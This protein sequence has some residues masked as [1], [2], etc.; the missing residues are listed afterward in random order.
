[1]PNEFLTDAKITREAADILHN[2][3]TFLGTINRQFDNSFGNAGAKIGSQLKIRMPN[4]YTVRT[5]RTANPQSTNETSEALV[6][7]TQKGVDFEFYSDELTLSMDDFKKRYL[8][9]QMSV[10]AANIEADAF[11]MFKDVPNIA[12]AT[13]TA[14]TT[15][16]P[17]LNARR[18]LNEMLAPGAGRCVQINGAAMASMVNGLTG[19]YHESQQIAHQFMEG[20]IMRNSGMDYYENASV[21]VLTPGT[22][23]STT[24]VVSGDNQGEDG[25]IAYTGA[26]AASTWVKGQ[27]ITIA[28]VYAV[29]PETKAKYDWLKQFV[30][31][32]N[33]TASGGAGTLSIYPTIV[34]SGARQNVD[35]AAVTG[36][37][38]TPHHTASTDATMNCAY[39]RD[40][41][42][43]VTA[44]L[45]L[46]KGTD[47]AYRTRVDNLSLRFVRDYNVKEDQW[48]A[49]FDVLY[50]YK[51][52]RP[53][54]LACR[55]V[56]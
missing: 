27:I 52:V 47:M 46:P 48:I 6:I 49:R 50:G 13:G 10:L 29:H 35:A 9:P 32:A 17:F 18:R 12:N 39:D 30:I 42:A 19:L 4:E 56:G 40:A 45:E 34:T 11:S 36:A 44:D 16:S 21:P 53:E 2:K 20:F 26:D 38:I 41:F 55:I 37:A 28:G 25:T 22:V 5:G 15:I 3:A 14:L 51:A 31:T 23:D 43:F 7:A 33:N 54:R 1:M 24:P 8:E